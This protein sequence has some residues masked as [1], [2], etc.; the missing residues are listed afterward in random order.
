[1]GKYNFSDEQDKRREDRRPKVKPRKP[2]PKARKP[3][4]KSR[5]RIKKKSKKL[6]IGERIYSVL[7]KDFLLDNPVCQC[8]QSGCTGEATEVHHKKGRGKWL[9]VV[10]FFLAVCRKCHDYIENHPKEAKAKGFS[11]PRI[12]HK[13]KP[14]IY[15]R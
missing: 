13:N 11:L 10:E 3:L 5:K 8:G 14:E 15:G 4:P 6:G 12:E 7:R 1:M 2:L 9:T